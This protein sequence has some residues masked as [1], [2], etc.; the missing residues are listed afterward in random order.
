MDFRCATVDDAEPIALLHADSWRR[1][2]RGAYAD[3]FLDGDVVADRR[4]VWSTRLAAPAG[5]ATTVAE[6]DGRLL[7]FVHVV[8]DQD[9]RWG[10]L[11]DNLHVTHD[12]H[13]TGIGRRLLGHAATGPMYLWVL[14]QNT[15]AQRFY[16]S[17]GA[18]PGET[19]PVSSDPARLNGSPLKLRMTW[20]SV[21][22]YKSCNL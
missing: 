17:C 16:L 14:Q 9:P 8:L 1:H 3:S 19:V 4:A 10:N 13:R 12:K 7:G 6:E 5:T 22:D 18:T 15:S 21:T 2:Y 11:V 20:R